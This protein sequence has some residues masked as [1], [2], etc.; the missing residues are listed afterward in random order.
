[1]LSSNQKKCDK[2]D[3][4]HDTKN[5]KSIN[6]KIGMWEKYI[7]DLLNMWRN[8]LHKYCLGAYIAGW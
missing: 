8:V 7:A 3:P 4:Q 5:L 2:D 6:W 1:M